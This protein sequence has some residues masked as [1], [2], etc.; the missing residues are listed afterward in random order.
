MVAPYLWHRGISRIDELF[1]SHADT[2]HFNGVAEL[3]ARFPVGRITLTPSFR[4][5]PTVEVAAALAAIDRRGIEIRVAEAGDRFD[6]G[7][8]RLDVLHPPY[9]GP[10]GIENERSLV[11]AVRHAGHTILL[12]GDLEKA[13]TARLLGLPPT[14]C[15]VLMAPHHGSRPAL[16]GTLVEWCRPKLVAVS[17]GAERGNSV[18]PGDG[19]PGAD[20][21]DT[22]TKGVITLR[23][24][25]SGLIA[26]S[27]RGGERAVVATGGE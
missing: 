6:A 20:V 24:H 14:P 11:L 22:W 1:L 13:G 10:P 23:S 12:T 16:P 17:R 9:D 26:E 27:F 19:G 8:V 15:D 3:L 18:R 7:E 25:R 4:D 21:W 5:K 2:D